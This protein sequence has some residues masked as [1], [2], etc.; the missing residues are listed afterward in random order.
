MTEDRKALIEIRKEL[1]EVRKELTVERNA[2]IEVRKILTEERKERDSLLDRIKCL[3]TEK[4]AY[5]QKRDVE[6][7]FDCCTIQESTNQRKRIK[8]EFENENSMNYDTSKDE[9]NAAFHSTSI[10]DDIVEPTQC[11]PYH[12]VS[13]KSKRTSPTN[14]SHGSNE[15]N[16]ENQN[17]SNWKAN[18]KSPTVLNKNSKKIEV[19][20]V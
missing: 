7:M 10:E 8:T 3:E 16:K 20:V 12:S 2:S 19:N 13:N 15:Q 4:Q 14:K 11:D 6:N 9:L 18:E 5:L 17:K 1:I